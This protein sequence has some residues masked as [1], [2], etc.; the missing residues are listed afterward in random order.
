MD[1]AFRIALLISVIAE[2]LHYNICTSGNSDH[3][4]LSS[5]PMPDNVH[6]RPVVLLETINVAVSLLR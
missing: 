4:Y 5:T 2:I 3:L 1:L 6:I